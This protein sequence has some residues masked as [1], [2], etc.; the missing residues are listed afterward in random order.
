MLLVVSTR[1]F[2]QVAQRSSE[3]ATRKPTEQFLLHYDNAPRHTTL[4]VQQL[5]AKKKIPVVIQPPYF[6]DL[7]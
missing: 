4:I 6:S 5:L 2:A 3:E 1:K 7:A